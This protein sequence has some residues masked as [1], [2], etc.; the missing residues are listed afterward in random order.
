MSGDAQ[1]GSAFRLLPAV[2]CKLKTPCQAHRLRG[3]IVCGETRRAAAKS[4]LHLQKDRCFKEQKICSNSSTLPAGDDVLWAQGVSARSVLHLQKAR[5]LEGAGKAALELDAA[6]PSLTGFQFHVYSNASCGRQ[7]QTSR[8]FFDPCKK[9]RG[10]RNSRSTPAGTASCPFNQNL[11]SETPSRPFNQ[12]PPSETPS[13]PFN[14]N[15]PS[16]TP[17]LPLNPESPSETPLHPFNK[18]SKPLYISKSKV[19]DIS[20][21]RPLSAA[22]LVSWT[23]PQ[24][25]ITTP[26][27]SH[28]SR[29]I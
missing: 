10:L 29:R 21:S 4:V 15:P 20:T 9:Q 3:G 23:A 14:Q 22:F 17:S 16:K 12:N 13:R 24:S 2:F 27:Y 18:Y 19:T 26:S 6:C 28:S 8:R 1:S 11:P 5:C 25:E 7:F